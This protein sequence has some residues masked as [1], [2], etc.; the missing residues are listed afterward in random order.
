MRFHEFM[1]EDYLEIKETDSEP[2]DDMAAAV[3]T[4]LQFLKH[5][6]VEKNATPKLKTQSFISLVQN[7]G[8]KNFGYDDLVAA[9]D[10]PLTQNLI[11][12]FNKDEV[13]INLDNSESDGEGDNN[14]KPSRDPEQTVNSMAKSASKL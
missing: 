2:V 8:Y 13:T 6:A 7:A 3:S 5:R 9:N 10:S 4:V 1:P 14:A 11:K 12:S